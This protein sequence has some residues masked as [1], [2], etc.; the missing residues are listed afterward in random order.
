MKRGK[1]K[2]KKQ[3]KALAACRR[4][5][6]Q[7]EQLQAQR[8]DKEKDIK[9]K[10]DELQMFHLLNTAVNRGDSFQKMC[11]TMARQI[12]KLCNCIG[13]AIYIPCDS[14]QC[15]ILQKNHYVKSWLRKI[16]SVRGLS[17]PS[18]IKIQLKKSSMYKKAIDRQEPLIINSPARIKKMIS[19]FTPDRLTQKT[20]ARLWKMMNIHSVALI[21]LVAQNDTVGLLDLSKDTLFTPY[22]IDC[23]KRIAGQITIILNHWRARNILRESEEKYMHI[24]ENSIDGIAMAQEGKI[25]YV[26]KAYCEI[27]GY[28]KSELIGKDLSTVV[29]P[30]DRELIKTRAQK[31][32]T[33]KKVPHHYVFMGMKKDD[34]RL[35]IEVSSSPAFRHKGK[36][37]ILAIL[38]DVTERIRMEKALKESEERFR[39]FM[40][41]A[42]DGFV[43]L[44]EQL[45]VIDANEYVLK[46]FNKTK[47][48]ILGINIIDVSFDAWESGRY[49]EYL[50]VLETGKSF[51]VNAIAPPE[52]GSRHLMLKAFKVGTGLGMIVR[53]I[54]TQMRIEE[55]L[56]I[57][58][59]R[60]QYL[61]SSTS[62]AVYTAKAW[63]DFGAT[64]I[65]DTV[66]ELFGYKSGQFI[67][68]SA[69][70][71]EHVHPDDQAHVLAEVRKIYK[72]TQH[73]YEYRFRCKNGTYV[74]VRDHMKLVYDDQDK[75]FEI[76]G[77]LVDITEEK[78]NTKKS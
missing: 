61:L 11:D 14:N 21:P 27:F 23:F 22:E 1:R 45:N 13:A 50:K 46:Q 3:Q 55:E 62:A 32:I 70:W 69:F 49:F 8:I 76:I 24:A 52:L 64:F 60:L 41:S 33:G 5:C 78:K 51:T 71:L 31:R 40:D 75:P 56:R 28:P 59:E 53:D 47:N 43:L 17:V 26:N 9:K 2:P 7:L 30:E 38:R 44:D 12:L 57:A 16:R 36:P 42:T 10:R 29:A 35:F 34:T 19:E 63:G 74:W 72:K 68:D 15:L 58:N 54:T 20:V 39:E 37:T 18:Q 25:I 66:E 67:E 4:K 65:S 6:A 48:S 77:Y 73:A